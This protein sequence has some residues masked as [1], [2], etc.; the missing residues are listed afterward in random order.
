MTSVMYPTAR[1]RT[2]IDAAEEMM[3][4]AMA[5]YDSSHDAYHGEHEPS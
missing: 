1:E 4:E 3:V 2:V 5:R